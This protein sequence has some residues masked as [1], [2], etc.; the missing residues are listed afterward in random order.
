MDKRCSSVPDD[1]GKDGDTCGCRGDGKN[2]QLFTFG[3]GGI[4]A[5]C[6]AI[7]LLG[8][9]AALGGIASVLGLST[10]L[11]YLILVGLA[12]SFSALIVLL[13][14]KNRRA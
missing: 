4:V 10:G 2:S 13:Y 1:A 8:G 6:G 14:Q 9:A 7:E 5:C 3:L 11:T 12:G